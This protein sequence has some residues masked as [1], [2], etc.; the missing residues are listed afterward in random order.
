VN[1]DVGY[2]QIIEG[3]RT[4]MIGRARIAWNPAM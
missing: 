3:I 2:E 4:P 1:V